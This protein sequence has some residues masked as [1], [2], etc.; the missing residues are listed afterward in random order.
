MADMKVTCPI[1]GAKFT[2]ADNMKVHMQCSHGTSVGNIR[3]NGGAS[4]G[5]V[6]DT[7]GASGTTM[8]NAGASVGNVG[9]PKNKA[10]IL[11]GDG[12]MQDGERRNR[13]VHGDRYKQGEGETLEEIDMLRDESALETESTLGQVASQSSLGQL[14]QL[15]LV[16]YTSPGQVPSD[17]SLDQGTP[18]MTLEQEY[19][20]TEASDIFKSSSTETEWDQ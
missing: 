7:S 5:N 20:E 16:S 8:G 18:E 19:L 2:R 1:C 14:G 17:V 9:A 11:E 10:G 13:R 12:R 15:G 4:V 6:R 3:D